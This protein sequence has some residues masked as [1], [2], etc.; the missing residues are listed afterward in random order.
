MPKI[1]TGKVVIAGDQLDDYLQALEAAEKARAP[2]RQY[3][4]NRRFVQPGATMR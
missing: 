3:G 4:G 1:F 2:F